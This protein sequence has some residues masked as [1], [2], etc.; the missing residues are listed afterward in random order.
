MYEFLVR[1]QGN[2]VF[3]HEE[4]IFADN[5]R[6]AAEQAEGI[7]VRLQHATIEVLR[8]VSVTKIPPAII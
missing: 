7:M 2:D 3:R 8:I 4:T 1:I 6:E 5:I